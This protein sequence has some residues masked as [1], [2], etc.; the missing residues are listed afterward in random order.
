MIYFVDDITDAH[1]DT[2][3][4]HE[5]LPQ[6]KRRSRSTHRSRNIRARMNGL[7][8]E[9]IKMNNITKSY[10]HV[11]KKARKMIPR[12]G[13]CNKRC[14]IDSKCTACPSI[15]EAQRSNLF[16]KYWRMTWD[17]RKVYVASRVTSHHVTRR[18]RLDQTNTPSHRN[19]SFKY[20]FIVD[21]KDVPVCKNFFLGTLN[22]K[23]SPIR[24]WSLCGTDKGM[25]S[26]LK[27]M[28][29]RSHPDINK[30]DALKT[31]FSSLVKM[32]SHYCRAETNKVYLEP[33]FESIAHLYREYIIFCTEGNLPIGSIT[34]MKQHIATSNLAIYKPR[35]DQCD[36][37]T[38]YNA[39]NVDENEY[40]EHMKKKEEARAEKKQ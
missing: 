34:I 14:K 8:Y 23:P 31:F 19:F 21:G 11:Q 22:M 15:T 39:G 7:P 12:Q 25:V 28:P 17:Q 9:G 36:T 27:Q 38:A 37:C 6:I 16:R 4:V 29:R 13:L 33:I 32:P 1:D 20:S 30:R 18:R 5:N 40:Q 10:E 3:I 2:I 26:P 24:K 35:K